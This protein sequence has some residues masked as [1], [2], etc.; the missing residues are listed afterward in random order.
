MLTINY[1]K[2]LTNLQLKIYN[3]LA[4]EHNPALEFLISFLYSLLEKSIKIAEVIKDILIVPIFQIFGIFIMLIVLLFNVIASNPITTIPINKTIINTTIKPIVETN[5]KSH[6]LSF[7]NKVDNIPPPITLGE[8]IQP[9]KAIKEQRLLLEEKPLLLLPFKAVEAEKVID[10]INNIS[11]PY[12]REAVKKKREQLEK[13]ANFK[14]TLLD[15]EKIKSCA[16]DLTIPNNSKPFIHY[17][18]NRF[19]PTCSFIKSGKN[20][21]IIR[22]VLMKARADKKTLIYGTFTTKNVTADN[23][24][25]EIEKINIAFTKTL[26]IPKKMKDNIVGYVKKLEIKFNEARNDYNVH[27]HTVIAVSNYHKNHISIDEYHD[28]FKRYTKDNDIIKPDI[29]VIGKTDKDITKV[30][31]YLAKEDLIQNM[32]HSD[33]VSDNIYNAV[34]NKRLLEFCLSFRELK[35][36]A[37]NILT[38]NKVSIRKNQMPI[39][40]TL[41]WN[42]KKKIYI[43]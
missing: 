29:K 38:T 18:N 2:K 34:K 8:E 11:N 39:L 28:Y 31:N 14:G 7:I 21:D 27:I 37:E 32:L 33:E 20:A 10:E 16:I 26:T 36:K 42:D 6:I 35:R 4:E 3:Y 5:F 13:I 9:N 15:I 24:T 41:T 23:L 25:A 17:C 1:S 40:T 12:V 22:K 43:S 30:S 19:C